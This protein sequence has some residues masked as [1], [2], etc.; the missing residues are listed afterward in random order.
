MLSF[1]ITISLKLLIVMIQAWYSQD[2]SCYGQDIIYLVMV[3]TS[4]QFWFEIS[5]VSDKDEY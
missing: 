2:I 4:I 1:Y 3:M 5:E